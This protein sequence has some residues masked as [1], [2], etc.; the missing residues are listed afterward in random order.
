MFVADDC[1]ANISAGVTSWFKS[2][3]NFGVSNNTASS[4]TLSWTTTPTVDLST[5]TTAC[6]VYFEDFVNVNVIAVSGSTYGISSDGA[7]GIR[8]LAGSSAWQSA[9]G[10]AGTFVAGQWYSYIMEFS[11]GNMKAWVDGEL[12]ATGTYTGSVGLVSPDLMQFCNMSVAGVVIYDRILT[13]SERN[14]LSKLP[15]E[16]KLNYLPFSALANTNAVTC[17]VTAIDATGAVLDTNLVTV[18]T[19]G[20]NPRS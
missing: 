8:F 9:A 14:I 17:K 6:W 10:S 1:D 15:W 7:G 5:S 18:G 2:T 13:D 20:I 16:A 3:N 4:S 19:A 11:G 12:K